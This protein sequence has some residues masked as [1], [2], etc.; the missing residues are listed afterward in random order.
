[1]YKKKNGP[2]D[3]GANLLT[4]QN[5]SAC[6]DRLEGD[7]AEDTGSVKEVFQSRHHRKLKPIQDQSLG[8]G[9]NGTITSQLCD[10]TAV[11][12]LRQS[13]QTGNIH[14]L[15]TNNYSFCLHDADLFDADCCAAPLASAHTITIV[16]YTGFSSVYW[17]AKQYW[18]AFSV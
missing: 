13:A 10:F 6:I 7:A 3:S 1:M 9:M 2:L 4:R 16:C 15:E 18:S 8:S 14:G 11:S 17:M 12:T 5:S